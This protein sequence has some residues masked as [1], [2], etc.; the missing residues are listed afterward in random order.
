MATASTCFCCVSLLL[1]QAPSA[2]LSR[3]HARLLIV[4]VCDGLC[5][6]TFEQLHNQSTHDVMLLAVPDC[7]HFHEAIQDR[8]DD[9]SCSKVAARKAD[10]LAYLLS[11][12]IISPKV[13][14]LTRHVNKLLVV[15]LGQILNGHLINRLCQIQHLQS[16][17]TI[18]IQ[19]T[20]PGCYASYYQATVWQQRQ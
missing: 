9:S 8:Q 14:T 10:C 11:V 2:R 1:M 16:H 4:N 5:H 18:H 19:Y 17:M 3:V 7:S 20:R 12:L 15:I 13:N 6:V